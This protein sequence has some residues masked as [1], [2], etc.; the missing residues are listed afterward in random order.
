MSKMYHDS[1][2]NQAIV[3]RFTV[4]NTDES[5]H[6]RKNPLNKVTYYTSSDQEQIRHIYNDITDRINQ[7]GS[8][9]GDG[10]ANNYGVGNAI[11]LN[12]EREDE[13]DFITTEDLTETQM[14][15]YLQNKSHRAYQVEKEKNLYRESEDQDGLKTTIKQNIIQRTTTLTPLEKQVFEWTLF[16]RLSFEFLLAL[17]LALL[18]DFSRFQPVDCAPETAF[19][20][21]SQ[22]VSQMIRQPNGC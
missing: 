9:I 13:L 21:F 2:N 11:A 17:F 4:E 6:I 14:Q 15:Q 19:R 1:N 10:R 3:H 16:F 22:P 12:Y 20:E 7:N 5:G 8:L 18:K